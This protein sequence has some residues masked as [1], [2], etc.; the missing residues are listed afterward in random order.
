M[1][2]TVKRR[3]YVFVYGCLLLP[4]A[5][6]LAIRIAP[7]LYSF[8]IGF[9]EWDLLSESKPFVGL[10]NYSKLIDDPVFAAALKNTA[11]YVLLGV[12]A[13]LVTGLTVALLLSNIPALRGL[14][15]TVYFIPYVTSVVAFSWVFRWML[16]KNGVV[17]GLLLTLGF[18]PHLF[19]FSLHEA[20]PLV[21]GAMVWHNIGFQMLIFLT[22]LQNI[23][24]PYYEAASID[25]AGRFRKF[26]S[27]TLPLLNPAIVFSTVIATISYLQSFTSVLNMTG[28]GPLNSTVSVVL[29]IYQLAFKH[30]RMGEAA[31]ATVMLFLLIMAVSLLQLK[32]L[33][34][35]ID[36]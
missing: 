22:G 25:G 17:N 13:Q 16:M 29:Y 3:K 19:L 7:V 27:I 30:F 8:Q 12:P 2:L 26:L 6:F 24:E 9:Y 10:D 34:R 18:E 33:S 21:S 32:L 31:A 1:F 15:R 36:Y 5:F 14:F 28:G 20:L 11:L 35:K 23:P 4:L